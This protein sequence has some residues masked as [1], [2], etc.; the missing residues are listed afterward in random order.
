M[1]ASEVNQP[2]GQTMNVPSAQEVQ[3][4]PVSISVPA[5]LL[6]FSMHSQ[7]HCRIPLSRWL[8]SPSACAAV[9]RGK[10]YAVACTSTLWLR[11]LTHRHHP[12]KPR[13]LL[14]NFRFTDVPPS[15]ASSAASAAAD[16]RPAY[17]STEL[18]AYARKRL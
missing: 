18:A 13:A 10:M 15:P 9:A 3:Q 2:Q 8:L 4:Q 16:S 17:H 12:G 14:L 6:G 1:P 5:R 7:P 11:S